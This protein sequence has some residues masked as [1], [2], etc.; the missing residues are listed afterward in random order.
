M[1]SGSSVCRWNSG[2]DLLSGTAADSLRGKMA[3][4]G[5]LVSDIMKKETMAANGRKGETTG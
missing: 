5:S 4:P 2:R 3:F 1:I